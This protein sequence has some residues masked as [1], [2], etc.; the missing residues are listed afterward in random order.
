MADASSDINVPTVR[1]EII[2]EVISITKN[3]IMDVFQDLYKKVKIENKSRRFILRDFQIA[4]RA[5]ASWTVEDIK[6]KTKGFDNL[7]LNTL[8]E[9]LTNMGCDVITWDEVLFECYLSIARE[10][11]RKP[12]LLY[13]GVSISIYQEN[14]SLFEKIITNVL[15]TQL[16]R[17]TECLMVQENIMKAISNSNQKLEPE[18]EYN[19]QE[20]KQPLLSEYEVT[21]TKVT[22]PNIVDNDD[23]ISDKVSDISKHS[24]HSEESQESEHDTEDEDDVKSV[25]GNRIN[26]VSSP[27]ESEN[28]SDNDFKTQTTRKDRTPL[29]RANSTTSKLDI[30][31]IIPRTYKA[32]SDDKPV[33][34]KKQVKDA[35]KKYYNPQKT[36]NLLKKKPV[37]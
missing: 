16:R 28:E 17:L 14:A 30:L 23:I 24:K 1:H 3:P 32:T 36:I 11:W 18:N 37:F 22:V 34:I 35:Y 5:V 7:R 29:S 33:I 9:R 13:D 10:L 12:Y 25:K 21:E 8:A 26:I 19:Y 31:D 6:E 15:K 4:L 2:S 27:Y 20:I